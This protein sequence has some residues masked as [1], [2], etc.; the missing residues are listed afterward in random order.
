MTT[1]YQNLQQNPDKTQ[2]L[3]Q[4]MLTVQ[5]KYPNP[6]DWDAFTDMGDAR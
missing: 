2:A 6:E 1:F 3:R 4:A 5:Q